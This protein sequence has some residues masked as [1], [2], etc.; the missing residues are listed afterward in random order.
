VRANV[1]GRWDGTRGPKS[2][3]AAKLDEFQINPD[4]ARRQAALIE[5][6]FGIPASTAFRVAELAFAVSA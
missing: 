5:R 4:P 1:H 3:K 2:V 6:R